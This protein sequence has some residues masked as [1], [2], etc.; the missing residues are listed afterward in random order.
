MGNKYNETGAVELNTEVKL[1][2]KVNTSNFKTELPFTIN[3]IYEDVKPLN[4]NSLEE[5][6]N[7]KLKILK[8]FYI[9]LYKRNKA[10]SI[11]TDNKLYYIIDLN[12]VG[13]NEIAKLLV[14]RRP[15][16]IVV[17]INQYKEF[18]LDETTSF[19]DLRFIIKLLWRVD[20]RNAKGLLDYVNLPQESRSN[21]YLFSINLI[22]I[23]REINIYVERNKINSKLMLEL[24]I[25]KEGIMC[26]KRGIPIDIDKYRMYKDDINKEY[27]ELT[28][29]IKSKYNKEFDFNNNMTILKYLN[30]KECTP[31]L[32][33]SILKGECIQLY[34][35]L[36]LHKCYKSFNEHSIRGD[37]FIVKYDTSNLHEI[38]VNAIPEKQYLDNNIILIEGVFNDLYLRILT[39]LTRN[40]RLIVATST[41]DFL[42][43]INET[44]LEDNGIGIFSEILIKSYANNYFE[45]AEIQTY[46]QKNYKTAINI[47]DINYIRTLFSEKA[48]DLLKF[49]LEFDGKDV[50]YERFNKNIFHP[51]T[52]LDNYIKQIMSLVYKTAIQYVQNTIKEYMLKYSN[53]DTMEIELIGFYNYKIILKCSNKARSTAVD[54]LN[55]YMAMSYKKYIKN[56]KYYNITAV[57]VNNGEYNSEN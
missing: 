42:G 43:Y 16:K 48:P 40:D 6:K 24:D 1:K 18:I 12:E 35:D 56:T 36:M 25:F 41:N 52:S 44:L 31:S 8:S 54:I 19:W 10:L 30:E 55:R 50:I 49:F 37:R 38:K 29:D 28:K 34:N 15:K 53:D 7:I 23:A 4:I 3:P 20:V 11:V 47:N 21:V 9:Y 27:L 33:P 14:Y 51:D 26:E 45:P 46:A 57:I 13:V 17:G 2:P 39:E 32:E 5:F 22:Q